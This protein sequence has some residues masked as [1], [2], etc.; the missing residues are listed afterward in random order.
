MGY[1]L[2]ADLPPVN[3][4]YVAFFTMLV[5]FFFGTCAHLS[6]GTYGVVALMVQSTLERYDGKLFS[7]EM[8]NETNNDTL[9]INSGFLSNDP[10]EARVMIASALAIYVGIIHVTLVKHTKVM[11]L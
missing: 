6:I 8:V 3:G 5:Y 4:L 10:D 11:D 7:S 1:S 2:M 9:P